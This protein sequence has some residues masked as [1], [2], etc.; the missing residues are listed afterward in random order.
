MAIKLKTGKYKI[1]HIPGQKVGCTTNIEKRV[2]KEQGF[3]RSEFEIIF[4]TDNIK[5][6]AEAERTLQKDLGYKVDIKPYDKL[7]VSADGVKVNVTDQTTTFPVPYNEINALHIA[8]L[9]WETQYGK[10]TIDASDKIDWILDN[11]KKSM[12]SKDRSYIY[13]KALYEA[14]PFQKHMN[15]IT[16]KDIRQ[17]AETRGITAN[18]DSKTQYVK[19]MEEAGELAEALLKKDKKEIKDAIGDMV[20]VLT[21]LSSLEGFKIEDCIDHAYNEIVNRTGKMIN[22]T[23]VKDE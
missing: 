20:V 16:F 17:W 21:N 23:F 3:K 7:F 12:F 11:I 22:G 14:G 2:I 15:T 5:E 10:V 19:L 8:D 4:E 9:Q 13:N 6:A 1:Y 18:G